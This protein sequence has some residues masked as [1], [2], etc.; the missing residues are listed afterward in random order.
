LN[1]IRVHEDF[2]VIAIGLPTPKYKGNP[3]DPPL[4]SRFQ[5]HLVTMPSYDDYTKMLIQN[6]SNVDPKTIK[7]I[8]DFAYSFYAS[9]ESSLS[10]LN[11]PDFPVENVEKVVRIMNNTSNNSLSLNAVK[12]VNKIYPY[13]VILKEDENNLKFYFE[14]M[15]KFNLSLENKSEEEMLMNKKSGQFLNKIDYELVSVKDHHQQQKKLVEFKIKNKN[16]IIT[17]PV[18]SGVTNAKCHDKSD[19][20]IMNDYHSSE[21]VNMILSHSS[22]S[23]FCLIGSPGCGKTELINQFAK[24]L[25]YN[26]Q[27]V[28][29]Y[30]DM[31]TRDLIQQRITMPNGDTRWQNSPIINAAL[32]GDLVV[33]GNN[34]FN[35]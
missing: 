2:R 26:V 22:E 11:L 28:H 27:T 33:L 23:D 4:R 25:D 31:S 30:K 15:K 16:D 3:L 35:N 24:H 18:T 5:A 32:T 9:N 21:L 19:S 8:T 1:L 29:L 6:N 13:Q 10:T 12:L 17:I 7:N 34:F 20:F 14:L